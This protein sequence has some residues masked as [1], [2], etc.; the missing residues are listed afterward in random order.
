MSLISHTHSHRW[1]QTHTS[2]HIPQ[3]DFH[4][5]D[6]IRSSDSIELAVRLEYR[7]S[8]K[9]ASN[10]RDL[11]PWGSFALPLSACPFKHPSLT[12]LQV[13]SA[14]VLLGP[15]QVWDA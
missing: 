7:V 14:E 1:T 2:I 8:K 15:L 10:F 11:H 13:G 12:G 4:L 6:D 3:V 5:K 9:W